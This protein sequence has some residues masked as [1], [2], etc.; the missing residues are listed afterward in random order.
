MRSEKP[1]NHFSIGIFDDVA[2]ALDFD[3]KAVQ[4]VVSNID[5]LRKALPEQMQ[6]CLA[7][8]PNVDRSLGGFEG[9]MAAQQCLPNNA[10]RDKFAAEYSVLGRI[11]EALSPDPCLSPYEKDFRWLSAHRPA[12]FA[13]QAQDLHHSG[14]AGDATQASAE[15]GER[16][17]EHV[18]NYNQKVISASGRFQLCEGVQR[19]GQHRLARQRLMQL[20]L[21][22][23]AAAETG[24]QHHHAKAQAHVRG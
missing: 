12:S 17:L 18:H 7:F 24:G 4:R 6:K 14:A 19:P 13:W 22:P 16:L 8:F 23:E 9:L 3:E 11:W 21:G 5:E 20:A 15:K 2:Q 10:A 1:R